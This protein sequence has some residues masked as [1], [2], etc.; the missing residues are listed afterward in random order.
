MTGVNSGS[1]LRKMQRFVTILELG[2][3]VLE[4]HMSIKTVSCLAA[5]LYSKN[6]IIRQNAKLNSLPETTHCAPF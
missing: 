4:T 5:I 2:E 3:G 1:D 6:I